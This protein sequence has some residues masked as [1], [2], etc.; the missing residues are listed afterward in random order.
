MLREWMKFLL[1]RSHR[2]YPYPLPVLLPAKCWAV[3]LCVK[4]CH[5]T[6]SIINRHLP[7]TIRLWERI[8]QDWGHIFVTTSA[9]N[10]TFC[11]RRHSEMFRY[12]SPYLCCYAATSRKPGIPPHPLTAIPTFPNEMISPVRNSKGYFVGDLPLNTRMVF[13]HDSALYSIKFVLTFCR[14][15]DIIYVKR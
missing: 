2:R 4:V 7:P 13:S 10:F 9:I 1:P 6:H 14:N 12:T 3:T 11:F 5:Q 8:G 15:S